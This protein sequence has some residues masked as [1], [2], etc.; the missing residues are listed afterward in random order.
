M[1]A[2]HRQRF[3]PIPGACAKLALSPAELSDAI[4]H[5][6]LAAVETPEGTRVTEKAIE[7]FCAKGRRRKLAAMGEITRISIEMGHED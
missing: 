3:L 5:G 1:S 2:E 7:R 6:D 4:D